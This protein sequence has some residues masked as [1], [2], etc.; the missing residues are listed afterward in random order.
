MQA[1]ADVDLIE[2][3]RTNPWF[4]ACSVGLQDELLE[5]AFLRRIDSGK[6]LWVR[7]DAPI[8]MFC[9]VSGALRVG[10]VDAVGRQSV[11]TWIEPYEWFGEI[12]MFDGLATT[13]DVIAEGDTHV[14]CVRRDAIEAIAARDPAVWREIGRLTCRK[15]RMMFLVIEGLSALPIANRLAARLLIFSNTARGAGAPPR[16]VIPLPQDQLALMVA[17]SRQTVNRELKRLES[18]GVIA[19]RYGQ[20]ENLDHA[21]LRRHARINQG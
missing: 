7:R 17:A 21:A 18:K 1:Q 9:V 8:G 11:L 16:T 20:I 14:L 3:L 4:G 6:A 13:H 5:A 2:M 19:L 15:L 10:Y 12:S